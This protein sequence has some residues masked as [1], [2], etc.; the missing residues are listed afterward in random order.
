MGNTKLSNNLP[1]G[2][3]R[4]VFSGRNPREIENV[5]KKPAI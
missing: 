5:P 3:C 2:P 4:A 1:P